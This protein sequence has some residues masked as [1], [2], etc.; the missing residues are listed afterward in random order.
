MNDYSV[1]LNAGMDAIIE[2]SKA[3]QNIGVIFTDD[4]IEQAAEIRDRVGCKF[5]GWYHVD[6]ICIDYTKM[7]VAGDH[8]I[9]DGFYIDPIHSVPST[10]R[11]R[12]GDPFTGF[13]VSIANVKEMMDVAKLNNLAI[14]IN[15][16][17]DN[18]RSILN[19]HPI[20]IENIALMYSSV[21]IVI[22]HGG[23]YTSADRGM[24]WWTGRH[25]EE[26]RVQ[27]YSPMRLQLDFFDLCAFNDNIFLEI[28]STEN[29]IY[30]NNIAYI[31]RCADPNMRRSIIGKLV[32]GSNMGSPQ[33][34]P[35]ETQLSSMT[36]DNI[37]INYIEVISNNKVPRK[38]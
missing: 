21:P 24:D 9:I 32:I 2:Y 34:S 17:A 10:P 16:C 29:P 13:E 11:R 19:N 38:V 6:P 37:P 20:L 31:L 23:V 3:L 1:Y 14:M 27:S 18:L 4:E 7:L 36:A 22:H 5:F 33:Y 12:V 8:H 26:D 30:T 25:L 15:T 28:S 35:I